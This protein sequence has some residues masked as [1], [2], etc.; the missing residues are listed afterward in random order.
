MSQIT[1]NFSVDYTD[2]QLQ[3]DLELPT[4]GVTVVFG[5]SGCGKTTFLRCL[6][7]LTRSPSGYLRIHDEVWQ[8]ESKNLFRPVHQ[9]AI[10]MVFQDARL[11]PHLN[12][13]DNLNFGYKRIDNRDRRVDWQSTVDLLELEPLL[14]RRPNHLSGG[15]QQRVALGR[16]LLTSPRLLMMDEPLANLDLERK[17]EILPYLLRLRAELQIPIVYVSHS[18]N[19]VLQ[20][21]DTLVLMKAGRVTASGPANQVLRELSPAEQKETHLAGTVLD[22]VV[23]EHET[24]YGLTRVQFGEQVLFLPKQEVGVGDPLRV[25]IHAQDI[26]LVLGEEPFQ[27]SVL[28]TLKA[29][30]SEIGDIDP[31][32]HAVKI[33]LDV[34][35]PLMASITR[36]SLDRLQLKP[37]QTVFAHIKALKM[38]HEMDEV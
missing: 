14:D 27:T 15:E 37:G 17:R 16:A 23:A 36:K 12:V 5:K 10:G 33:Q 6:A 19:E 32:D 29:T 24:G 4:Q 2:F 25:H 9:R 26:S 8:D 34:G 22:T 7:G 1:A 31:T 20:L 13:R 30:I 38:V 11:F 3:T 35:L 18:L 28:N 21:V